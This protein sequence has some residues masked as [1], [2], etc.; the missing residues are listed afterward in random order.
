MLVEVG[1]GRIIDESIV[2]GVATFPCL[3]GLLAFREVPALLEALERL[4][5]DPD[6][7][8]C[9]GQGLAHPHRCG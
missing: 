5:R 6:M 7:L 9:D 1:S 8:V 4:R 2:D 3:P